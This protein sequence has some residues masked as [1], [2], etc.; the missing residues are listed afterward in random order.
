MNLNCQVGVSGY[1]KLA[2]IRPDGTRRE[3]AEFPNLITN[4][5]MD[6]LGSG[7]GG[8]YGIPFIFPI[9]KVGTGATTPAFTDS[10]LANAIATSGAIEGGT[11]SF[12]EA[13]GDTPA[14]WRPIKSWRF[15]VGAAPGTISEVGTF[16]PNGQAFS[17][18]LV[19][20]G[21]GNP[22]TV[23]VLADEVLDVTYEFRSYIDKTINSYTVSIGA[24]TYTLQIMPCDISNAPPL[25]LANRSTSNNSMYAVAM[26]SNVLGT[27]YQT[28]PSGGS[29]GSGSCAD[30]PYTSGTYYRDYRFTY[31]LSTG[32][33]ASGI[34]SIQLTFSSTKM[35]V[36][37]TPKVPKTNVKTFSITFRLSWA[38]YTL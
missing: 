12:V 24:D 1:F 8:S 31:D 29:S 33:F 5:G 17:R 2:A 14:Y 6:Q 21:S 16:D 4:N 27:V 19:L 28:I 37:F 22:T 3:L 9:C 38:R 36:G 20:D 35:K 32:N 26:E 10:D 13:V 18:A 15:A 7:G 30:Q 34:G 25:H 11:N 23:S